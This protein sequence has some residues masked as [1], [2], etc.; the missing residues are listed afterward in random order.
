MHGSFIN[1]YF[2][3]SRLSKQLP[4]VAAL[5][6]LRSPA[7]PGFGLLYFFQPC[8]CTADEEL[9]PAT[10]GKV[11]PSLM[12]RALWWFRSS[13]VVTVLAGLMYWGS[14]VASDANNG[15]STS[16]TAMASFFLIWTIT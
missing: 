6:P 9:D 3:A 5:D 13:A 14:I 4:D 2:T 16:G 8:E 7:S 15:S 12:L 11:I 1:R 10:K